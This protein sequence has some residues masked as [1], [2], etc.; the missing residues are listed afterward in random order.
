MQIKIGNKTIN[1]C[2]SNCEVTT[3]EEPRPEKCGKWKTEVK[4]H[5]TGWYH[6]SSSG[7][8]ARIQMTT[9][10]RFNSL[11]FCKQM[12][13]SQNRYIMDIQIRPV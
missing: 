13:S 8:C 2:D 7:R 4:S 10:T 12:M 1:K 3:S 5:L 11:Q 9:Y 6:S